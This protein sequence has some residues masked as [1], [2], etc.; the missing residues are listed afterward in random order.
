MIS[1]STIFVNIFRKMGCWCG[2]MFACLF[3]ILLIV[4]SYDSLGTASY[5]AIE[6]CRSYQ[7]CR[8]SVICGFITIGDHTLYQMKA[9]N[10][11]Y[12]HVGSSTIRGVSRYWMCELIATKC[13]FIASYVILSI[14]SDQ[15]L[16]DV[17]V[18]YLPSEMLYHDWY[19]PSVACSATWFCR[20]QVQDDQWIKLS[21]SS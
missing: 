14:T 4:F 21:N 15:I 19:E 20:K 5:I 8:N 13:F 7:C 2:A 17:S 12:Y 16:T 6:D 3:I 9:R 1:P 10:S 18:A 11:H